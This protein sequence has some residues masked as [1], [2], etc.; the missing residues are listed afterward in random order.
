MKPMNPR[1]QRTAIFRLHG[2]YDDHV[3][4]VCGP[5]EYFGNFRKG[6]YRQRK[7]EYGSRKLGKIERNMVNGGGDPE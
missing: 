7:G 3:H 6:V 1:L 5:W 2:T 4:N